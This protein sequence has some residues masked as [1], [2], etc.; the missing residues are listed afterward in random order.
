MTGLL[1][2]LLGVQLTMAVFSSALINI[3]KIIKSIII[4]FKNNIA[5]LKTEK[6]V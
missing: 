3:D 1:L 6:K 4:Y 2:L 5:F